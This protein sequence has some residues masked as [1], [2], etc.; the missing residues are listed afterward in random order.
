MTNSGPTL[1]DILNDLAVAEPITGDLLQ[2]YVD[3]YPQF[4]GEI[5]DFALE[6][7][8]PSADEDEPVTPAVTAAGKRMY[9]Q[10]MAILPPQMMPRNPLK[11]LDMAG[12]ERATGIARPLLD[13]MK[14]GL[15]IVGTI[16][17]GV[18]VKLAAYVRQTTDELR[19][20]LAGAPSTDAALEFKSRGKPETRQPRT[21]DYYFENS[22]LTDGEKRATLEE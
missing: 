14:K 2:R 6:C 7:E 3:A 9:D 20:G 17:D 4:A 12:V 22:G 11:D 18:L 1:D 15:M 8:T 5:L 10:L 13:A 16:P 19:A 21:F